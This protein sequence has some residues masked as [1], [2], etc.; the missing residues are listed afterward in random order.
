M[1]STPAHFVLRVMALEKETMAVIWLSADKRAAAD[2]AFLYIRTSLLKRWWKSCELILWGPAVE[3]AV[4]SPD[5][6]YELALL[7]H[8]GAEITACEACAVR[9][10]VCD[11]LCELGIAVKGMSEHLTELL[12]DDI[13]L[14]LI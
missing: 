5:I 6:R 8:L 7:Q 13:P 3:A 10:G 14:M 9:Y 4:S 2:M 11:K 1:I 12:K